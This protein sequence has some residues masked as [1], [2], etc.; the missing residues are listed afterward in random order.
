MITMSHPAAGTYEDPSLVSSNIE[1]GSLS[2]ELS[3]RTSS[4]S[5]DK[6][7]QTT[8]WRP[9][10]DLSTAKE[11]FL[12]FCTEVLQYNVEDEDD[13][14][15]DNARNTALA[16]AES[17]YAKLPN[18]WRKPRVATD[19]GGGVRLT[20]KSGGREIRAVFPA[21][22]RRVQYLYKEEGDVHSMIP[23]FTSATLCDQLNW[24]ILTK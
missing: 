1:Q 5:S 19:G 11:S 21:D 6:V 14:I 20:W 18:K 10:L 12:A 23:N 8:S 2:T 3:K 16:L 13:Q 4:L 9:P 15:A 22:P 17:A 24:L 7:T